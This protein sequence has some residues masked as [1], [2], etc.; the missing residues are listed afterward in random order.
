MTWISCDEAKPICSNCNRLELECIYDRVPQSPNS[1]KSSPTSSTDKSTVVLPESESRRRLELR[2]FYQ[3]ITDTGPSLALDDIS[4]HF[5]VKT[6]C[7]LAL[8]SDA[9]LYSMYMIAALH[10]EQRSNFTDMEADATCQTY[11]NMAIHEHHKEVA[12]ISA[13]NVEYI[14]LTSSMLRVHSFVQ[15][16]GRSLQPYTAPIDWLRISNTSKI[17][18]RSAWDLVKDKPESVAHEMVKSVST[19][20]IDRENEELRQDL[21]HLLRREEPHELEEPWDS[22][23]EEVY[24]TTLNLIGGIWRAMKDK[25]CPATSIGRRVVIFPMMLRKQFADFVEELRPRAL[26]ILAHYFA[27]LSMLGKFWWVGDSGFREIQAISQILPEHWQ[28]LLDWPKKIL[29]EKDVT[30][31]LG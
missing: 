16:Q 26:V 25:Q 3:Y 11:V 8:E 13:Q 30:Y 21:K 14:C 1:N 24:A 2:L 20:L 19:W 15:L 5:W 12:E 23:T 17:L 28:R 22:E 6:L 31:T 18:F 7:R 10:T 4:A 9:L 27:L 29:Q